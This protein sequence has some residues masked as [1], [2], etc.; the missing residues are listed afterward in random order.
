[1]REHAFYHPEL[2]AAIRTSASQRASVWTEG[3]MSSDGT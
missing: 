3:K 2:D 1:M